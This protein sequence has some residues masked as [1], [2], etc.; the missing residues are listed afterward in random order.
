[1]ITII[2]RV[3]RINELNPI[4]TMSA[5]TFGVFEN[6]PADTLV[7]RITFTDADWPF[8][9][10]KYTIIGG[11]L[12]SPHKFYI[13]PDTGTVKTL[14]SIN[15]TIKKLIYSFGIYFIEKLDIGTS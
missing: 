5:F 13:E 3:S 7:G 8:N 10:I 2:I 11:N 15:N 12:G 14:I 4:G 6:S 9:N 1:M